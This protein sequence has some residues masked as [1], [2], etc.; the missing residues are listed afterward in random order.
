[1]K[2]LSSDTIFL[3]NSR[4]NPIK[5]IGSIAVLLSALSLH[6]YANE[7]VNQQYEDALIA[8]HNNKIDTSIIHLKNVLQ[9]QSDHLPSRILLAQALLAQGNGDLA[10]IELNNAKANNA[11]KNR[12]VTL[13][14]H[15]Y[16]LQHKYD[17]VIRITKAGSRGTKIETELL[18]YKGQAQIGQKLYRSADITFEEALI[19]APKNQLALLGRAQIAQIS[20]K[21]QQALQFIERSLAQPKPFINGWIMKANILAQLGKQKEALVAIDKAIEIDHSHFA[22][23]L[24]KAMLHINLSEYALAEPHIDIILSEIPNEPRAGYL[25]ALINANLDN[26]SDQSGTKKLTEVITT[27]AAV[28]DEIMKTTPDYYYLAGLTNFQYGNLLDAKRYLE[29]YLTYVDS[30]L[31]SIRMIALIELQTGSA[32]SAKNLLKK[33]NLTHPN[34]VDILTLLGMTYLQLKDANKAESYFKEVLKINPNS[35]RGISNLARSKMQS[36]E[37]KSA[38]D[39]LL[40][41][42]NNEVNS[43]QVKLLLIDSFENNQDIDKAISIAQE[44]IA[45]YPNDS[46]F[47]QRIGSLY[48]W[49]NQFAQA[50]EAFQKALNLDNTNIAAIV[51]LARM[52]IIKKDYV[53]ARSFLQDKL[54]EFPQNPLIMAEISDTYLFGGNIIESLSWTSKAYALANN[55]YYILSK[56]ANAL[57]QSEQLEK[58]IETVDFFIGQNTNSAGALR[59]IAQLYQ[60]QNKHQQAILALRDYVRKAQDKV[61]ASILLAQAQIIAGDSSGAI[62]SY[63]KAIVED[64]NSIPAHIGLVNL[65]I[66][67]KD[68]SFALNL[69]SNINKLTNSNSLE[70]V[71]LG[72]L[73]LALDN[74]KKSKSHYLAAL[75]ISAQKQAILGLYQSFKKEQNLALAIPYLKQWLKKHPNDLVVEISLADS[76]KHANKLELAATQY[77]QL[78]SNHGKMPILLNNAANIY[79]DLNNHQKAREYAKEAY[80]YLQDN[81]AIIDTYAWIESRLGNHKEALALFRYALTKDYDNAEIKYHL[82]VTLQKLQRVDEA[83][84]YLIEAVDSPQHF[85]EKAQAKALLSNW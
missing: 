39:A 63:K 20:S 69:I 36:G 44:L 16:L 38:I 54:E 1:M 28:P 4:K 35:E 70:Q 76:Y 17:E 56:Y 79:F 32:I 85:S 66:K 43:I 74:T 61:A 60:Q 73:Y 50:Q 12:L 21:P 10:E 67:N 24:T 48:G 9:Q 81:V 40:T 72:D 34:N 55:N 53:K 19:L 6:S 15:A 62:Q 65:V 80:S 75:K 58:A 7:A 22:A 78:I 27:L 2:K 41:I 31:D 71:L 30:H 57:T 14:A 47:Q 29:K 59:L 23:L 49:N 8:F 26:S 45:Q 3:S 37:Y 51:H 84:G 68:E 33:A 46:Y 82:A 13:F 42:K 64:Q 52:D 83:K 25:K 11:D 77:E 18:V 5:A